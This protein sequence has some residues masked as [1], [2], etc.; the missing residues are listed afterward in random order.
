MS[1]LIFVE[2]SSA[3]SMAPLH[4]NVIS[5]IGLRR[6]S[7]WDDRQSSNYL[8]P[9]RNRTQHQQLWCK[10]NGVLENSCQ[11]LWRRVCKNFQMH[12]AYG[13]HLLWNQEQRSSW[14][15]STVSWLS[16][17]LLCC[18]VVSTPTTT[19]KVMVPMCIETCWM[20]FMA[21]SWLDVSIY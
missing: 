20:G 10:K 3:G 4:P 5:L 21:N 12:M 14:L 1:R 11:T 8:F 16:L 9:K 2:Q 18:L 19:I 6:K 13:I 17:L 15:C 7:R